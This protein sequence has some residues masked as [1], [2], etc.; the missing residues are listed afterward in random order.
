MLFIPHDRRS[1]HLSHWD[2]AL[3]HDIDVIHNRASTVQ[4]RHI[5]GVVTEDGVVTNDRCTCPV[6][7]LF[8]TV[9]CVVPELMSHIV[10]IEA[11]VCAAAI[12][13]LGTAIP[14]TNVYP[15]TVTGYRCVQ[16]V[17]MLRLKIFVF[18]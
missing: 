3:L 11:P 16:L 14:V 6:I 17:S 5:R 9:W 8:E 2:A 12:R 1:Y 18:A 15:V 10:G 13:I 4:A 7:P